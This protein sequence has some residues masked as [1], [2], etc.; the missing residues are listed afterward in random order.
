MLFDSP[1]PVEPHDEADSGPRDARETSE[2]GLE[3]GDVSQILQ[4][5]ALTPTE[6]LRAAQDLLNTALRIR[7]RNADRGNPAGSR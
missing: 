2:W 3:W 4:K 1:P 5:L 7:A 6:R